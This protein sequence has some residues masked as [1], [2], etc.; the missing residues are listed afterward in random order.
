[1]TLDGVAALEAA[2]NRV[3]ARKLYQRSLELKKS[4]GDASGE[5]VTRIHLAG[6]DFSDG[7]PG[8]ARQALEQALVRASEIGHPE[9]Q[10]R[11]LGWLGLVDRAEGQ[12]AAARE[13]WTK[14]LEICNSLQLPAAIEEHTQQ[15]ASLIALENV[16][17]AWRAHDA[18]LS[19]GGVLVTS[20]QPGVP[21]AEA[22]LATGDILLHYN[23]TR[24]DKPAAFTSLF[25]R[26]APAATIRLEL[27]RGE[28]KLKLE[29]PRSLEGVVIGALPPRPATSVPSA[30]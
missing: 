28:K 18:V 2:A 24:I 12:L 13:R 30:P 20:V 1:M 8:D 15:L 29:I 23:S 3:E 22:G 17:R 9:Y 14:A 25:E 21:A 19:G 27:V 11:T 26:T 10:A 16:A 4:V 6:L 5:V 7:R